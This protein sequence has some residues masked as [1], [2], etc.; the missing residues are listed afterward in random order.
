MQREELGAWLRLLLTPGLGPVGQRRLLAAFG[1]PQAIFEQT[2]GALAAVAG[3]ALAQRLLKPPAG[4]AALCEATW[5]WQQ[6]PGHHLIAL[7]DPA[8]PAALLQ[9]ADPPP[10][11]HLAGDPALLRHALPIAVVG[12][13]NPTVQGLE[14]ARRFGQALGEA[15]ACVVSGLALGVDGAAHEGALA[16][17]A[18]TLAVVGTG[19]DITYP[20]RHAGLARRIETSGAVLSELPLGSPP[21]A[22]HFPR[23]NRLI[24]ALGRG[25]LVVEATLQSG[26]LIT[27]RL[28]AELGREVYAIPGSVHAPQARGCHA[29]IREGAKLVETAQDVLEDLQ[30]GGHTRPAAP[31]PADVNDTPLLQALGFDPMGLD[32]LQART[33]LPTEQLLAQ[34]LELE[35]EGRL[36]RLPGGLFQ[37]VAAA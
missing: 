14:H 17:G 16:V 37:R 34:L 20:R 33:G 23:R 18:P 10:L 27:A 24:A 11:L 3:P 31:T 21:L 15:G 5:R 30:P 19:L 2:P 26:S 36:A 22:P 29:L 8:Y 35:L 1:L 32:A 25:T 9:V 4:W 6:Q 28:A 12:S 7:G 13:R